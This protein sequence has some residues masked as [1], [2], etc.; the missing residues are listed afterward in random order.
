[1]SF[2]FYGSSLQLYGAK[3]LNHG[4]YQISIDSVV[5]P[6]VNGSVPDPGTFQTPLFSTT[7]LTTG[8]HT[9][10]MTNLESRYLDLDFVCCLNESFSSRYADKVHCR[11]SHC[12]LLLDKPTKLSSLQLCRTWTHRSSTFRNNSGIRTRP[13]LEC[14]LVDQ[15]SMYEP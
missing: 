2:Y 6:A 8:Y 10:K 4:A 9:V 3:R 13:V 5:Y 14:S 11:R 7:D 12:K 1:M 15:D